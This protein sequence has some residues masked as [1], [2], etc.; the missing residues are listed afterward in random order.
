[1]LPDQSSMY[2]VGLDATC[3][4]NDRVGYWK[5]VY[6]KPKPPAGPKADGLV[7]MGGVVLASI[8]RLPSTKVS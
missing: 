2:L 1:M 6:G 7:R 8:D 5:D 4:H 3:G